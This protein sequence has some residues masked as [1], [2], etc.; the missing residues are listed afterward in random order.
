MARY[1]HRAKELSEVFRHRQNKPIDTAVW[2]VE[3]LLKYKSTSETLHSYA[4]ELNW[5]VFNSLDAIMLIIVL[6]VVI[7][8]VCGIDTFMVFL[9]LVSFLLFCFLVFSHLLIRK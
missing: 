3:H 2:W 5:F 6:I 4:V 1:E 7:K 9:L 8:E